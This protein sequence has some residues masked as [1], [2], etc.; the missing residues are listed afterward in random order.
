VADDEHI[1]RLGGLLAETAHAHHE[2]TGGVNPPEWAPWYADYLQ[3]KIDGSVG[4]SPDPVTVESWL[5]M[6]DERHQAEEPETKYWP[7]LYARYIIED[8]AQEHEQH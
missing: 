3:G 4:F 6:A 8:Y 1:E 5:T 7:T 2:A